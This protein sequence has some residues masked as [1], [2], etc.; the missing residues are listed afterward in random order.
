[1]DEQGPADALWIH[2]DCW[3]PVVELTGRESIFLSG[4]IAGMKKAGIVSRREE[5]DVFKAARAGVEL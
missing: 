5:I 4:A 2:G 1:L 3:A